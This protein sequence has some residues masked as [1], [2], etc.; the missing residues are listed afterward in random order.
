MMTQLRDVMNSIGLLILRVGIGGYML[1]HGWGKFQM[2]LAGDFDQFGDPIGLGSGVSLV[3]VT[4]AEFLCAALVIIGL[5]TRVAAA[6]IV[7]AMG[8]AAFVAHAAD[9]WTMGQGAAL[10]HAGEAESWASK[11]PALMF[12]TVFLALVFTGGGRYSL[13]AAIGWYRRRQRHR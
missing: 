8:V 7:F 3:L 4:F 2:V 5:G 6:P 11:Q 10:Y 9:P 12:M 13:D 1:T